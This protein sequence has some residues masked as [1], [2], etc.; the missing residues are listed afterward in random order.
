VLQSRLPPQPLPIPV[1]QYWPPSGMQV[2]GVQVPVGWHWLFTQVSPS[3]HVPHSRL[4][5]QPLPMLPQYL[6]EPVPQVA[7]WQVGPPTHI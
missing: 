7:G 5:P 1:P 4:P 2:S 3:V 6:R